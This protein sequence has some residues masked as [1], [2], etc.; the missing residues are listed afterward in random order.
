VAFEGC[1]P[2]Y[3][4]QT[5]HF[6]SWVTYSPAT[7]V[8]DV[9]AL[10]AYY[11]NGIL[12]LDGNGEADTLLDALNYK[13]GSGTTGALR[14]LLRA[15]VAAL[16]NAANPTVD[17]PLSEAQ[18]IDQV[19]AAAATGDRNTILALASRLDQANNLGC[20]L[21]RAVTSGLLGTTATDMLFLPLIDN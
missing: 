6:G 15:G 18:V 14:N 21:G 17:Y 5:Q 9:F 12:D 16:L 8:Q 11:T 2:G 3:W 20:P 13:G 19:N 7:L 1:T 10:S 4:K